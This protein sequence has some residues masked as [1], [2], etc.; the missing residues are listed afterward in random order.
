MHEPPYQPDMFL[1][2]KVAE[3]QK[4]VESSPGYDYWATRCMREIKKLPKG[5]RYTGE[6][7]RVAIRDQTGEPLHHNHWGV[8]IKEAAKRGLIVRTGRYE[9]MQLPQSHGRESPQWEVL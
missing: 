5:Q 7:I 1:P 2:E 8:M 4:R 6:A 3:W 9:H